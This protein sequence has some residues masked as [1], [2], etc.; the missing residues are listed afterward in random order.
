MQ[1]F[2]RYQKTFIMMIV[3]AMTAP[4][5]IGMGTSVMSSSHPSSSQVATCQ[6]GTVIYEHELQ[7][8]LSLFSLGNIPVVQ[9]VCDEYQLLTLVAHHSFDQIQDEFKDKLAHIKQ[10]I[11]YHHPKI[12]SLSVMNLWKSQAPLF[13][14][15]L[16]KVQQA[17]ACLQTFLTYI[18]LYQEACRL[19]PVASK[20]ALLKEEALYPVQLKD[21][22]LKTVPHLLPFEPLQMEAWLGKQF[23]QQLVT[24]LFDLAALAK[25][26]GYHISFQ[27]A[28][29]ELHQSLFQ[30][31]KA[32]YGEN[33]VHPEH[34]CQLLSLYS[35]EFKLDEA[36]LI[37]LF[38]KLMRV[39]IYFK[40]LRHSASLDTSV[41]V[42]L[43]Q[44]DHTRIRADE[45]IDH[46]ISNILK[47]KDNR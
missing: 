13:Q 2:R 24:C 23:S 28:R 8:V 15:H 37:K 38:Q 31:L 22:Y 43:K 4:M 29:R 16:H 44:Q 14:E 11:P 47:D 41:N 39:R 34:I 18:A 19:D 21:P 30:A 12:S 25:K 6:D 33:N 5:I 46:V 7:A 35:Q 9:E 10:Y 26:Q 20:Q 27:E 3:I 36:D 1:F 45:K 32:R 40:D 17:D 42:S